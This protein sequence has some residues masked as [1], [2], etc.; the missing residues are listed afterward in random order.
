[1]AAEA[2]QR[3]AGSYSVYHSTLRDM[4][5]AA[6]AEH[7]RLTEMVTSKRSSISDK[8]A[9]LMGAKTESAAAERQ[10]AQTSK[11]IDALDAE[12]NNPDLDAVSLE[13]RAIKV[14]RDIDS[15]AE[16]KQSIMGEET[17]APDI[18]VVTGVD[19]TDG[20]LV[21]DKITADAV[22]SIT[23]ES[24]NEK[25]VPELSKQEGERVTDMIER[26]YCRT[27][28]QGNETLLRMEHGIN[29]ELLGSIGPI[30]DSML[31][32]YLCKNRKEH[33]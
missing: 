14:V 28:D 15:F 6:R 30:T 21:Y 27:D 25:D 33:E 18:Y 23:I 20:S 2:L 8:Q 22:G 24:V 12:W 19:H 5:E 4:I 7:A 16:F 26:V 1:M 31:G 32:A 13:N 10:L 17:K 11:E 3:T 29:G 9:N